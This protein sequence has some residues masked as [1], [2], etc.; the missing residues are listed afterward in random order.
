VGAYADYYFNKDDATLP[1]SAPLLLPPTF[2]HGWSARVN[3]G[4][5]LKT[6][7]AARFSVGGRGSNQFTTWSVR[8][9]A[10]LPF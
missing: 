9:R 8:G 10:S 1:I 7:T 2:I 6:E 5:A 3:S 4:I